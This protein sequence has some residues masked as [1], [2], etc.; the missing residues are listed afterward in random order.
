MNKLT[1]VQRFFRLLQLD[2]KDI[3]YV[4]LYAIFSGLI[5]LSLPLGVQAIIGMIAG[6]ALSA[7]LILLIVIVTLGTMMTGILKVM[8]LTVTE[9]IQRRIFARSSFE[10]AWRLPRIQYEKLLGDYPPELVNRFFDTL[11][12]Q[13][14]VPKLL[15]DVST[16]ALQIVFGLLLISLYHVTF[17]AFSLILLIT[18]T[19][20]FYYT[21]P[22]GLSTSLMESKYKYKVAHWLEEIGRAVTTFKLSG[23]SKLALKKAEKLVD[24]Y[25]DH[26]QSHFK[27]LMVQYGWMVAITTLITLSLLAIGSVLVIDNSITIGQFVA[28]EIIIILILGSVEKLILSI[29]TIYDMLTAVEKIGYVTDLPLEKGA[30]G[31]CFDQIDR[32]GKGLEVSFQNLSFCFP[33]SDRLVIDD[34]TLLVSAGEKICIL[35]P[36][37]SGKSTLIQLA[38]MLYTNFQGS[39]S[40]NGIPVRNLDYQ[41]IRMHIGD[42]MRDED[43]FRASLL[44]NLWMHDS[45]P[46][47]D[48][49]QKVISNMGL[50][51]YVAKLPN[52]Y[53]TELLPSGRNLPAS[54]RTKLLLARTLMGEPRLLALGDFGASLNSADRRKIADLLTD[55]NSIHT[56]LAVSDD[57]YFASK[58][59]RIIYLDDGKLVLSGTYTELVKEKRVA[60][61]LGLIPDDENLLN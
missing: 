7:A 41:N 17:V 14:G 10:F 18:L 50:T 22:R 8:Q 40:Y 15:T 29:D 44:D 42:Y 25:L 48:Q 5:T 12:L 55:P 31:I 52:G 4:Y 51:T 33:D 6:G 60:V 53:Q 1:A 45:E 49:V 27:I 30:E 23:Q 56:V 57:P 16:A 24:S 13:K 20:I 58:C 11:T 34:L 61:A 47:L 43:L 46:D 2:R 37:G 59:D 21:G 38:G 54:V 3:S 32:S 9:V 28:A 19:L 35:G 36:N 39:I 26:R